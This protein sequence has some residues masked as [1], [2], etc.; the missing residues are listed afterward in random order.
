MSGFRASLLFAC[1]LMYLARCIIRRLRSIT[2]NGAILT[3]DANVRMNADVFIFALR[4]S[5][6]NGL[7]CYHEIC[8]NIIGLSS[9]SARFT[10]YDYD[11]LINLKAS[12]VDRN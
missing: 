7:L 11:A 12:V 1:L 5:V 2:V 6:C 9:S 4:S 3:R 10:S 8:Y